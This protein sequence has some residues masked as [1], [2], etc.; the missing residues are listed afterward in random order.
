MSDDMPD[1][2][3]DMV[4]VD[5]GFAEVTQKLYAIF[6]NDFVS[7]KREL[8]GAEV[9]HDK[10]VQRGETYEEGFWHLI[11]RDS[12][13]NDQR[14]FDPRRAERLPW[15]APLLGHADD[16]CV[17]YWVC[18]ERAKSV[19]YVWLPEWDYVVILEMRK[20][21][22]RWQGGRVLPERTI[23]FLKTA[24]HVDGKS[25]KLSLE[26]KYERRV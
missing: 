14:L 22:P 13:G 9:W 12:V 15:C 17:Q 10:R 18:I 26:K 21:K 2:L 8:R 7:K 4:G 23:A 24:Y 1:W 5:G 11:T 3:P 25:Q 19:C 20:L 6:H 16:A